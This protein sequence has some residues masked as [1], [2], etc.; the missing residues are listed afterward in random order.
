MTTL[1][2]TQYGFQKIADALLPNRIA[3][4]GDA[5]TINGNTDKEHKHVSSVGEFA[6]VNAV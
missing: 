6:I 3:A 2:D 5:R 1:A 4:S